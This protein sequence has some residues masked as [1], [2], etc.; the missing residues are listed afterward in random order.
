MIAA[1]LVML[2]AVGLTTGEA[3]SIASFFSSNWESIGGWSLFIGLCIFIVIGAFREWWVP[4]SR[5]K[6]VELAASEQSKTL[7]STVD[8][9]KQQ[10]TANQITKYFFEQTVPKRGEPMP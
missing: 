6:R 10:T 4:G 7:A 5:Y 9:L 1:P 8:A 3:F 2:T